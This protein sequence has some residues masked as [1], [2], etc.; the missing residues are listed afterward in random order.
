MSFILVVANAILI[1]CVLFVLETECSVIYFKQIPFSF[2][3]GRNLEVESELTELPLV[4]LKAVLLD[5]LF[6]SSRAFDYSHD[7]SSCDLD[8]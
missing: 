6:S 2:V 5:R 7:I 1:I 8:I 4:F 3:L